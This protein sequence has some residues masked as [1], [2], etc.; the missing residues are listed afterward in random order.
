M[1]RLKSILKYTPS[2]SVQA[3]IFSVSETSG[4]ISQIPPVRKLFL[5]KPA[6]S[7][8]WMRTFF[9][10]RPHH[11]SLLAEWN[12]PKFEQVTQQN[13]EKAVGCAELADTRHYM[14][15]QSW[16]SGKWGI[17]WG[18]LEQ[19]LEW[20]N[21]PKAPASSNEAA[22]CSNQ[23]H[24]AQEGPDVARTLAHSFQHSLH[25]PFCPSA[26]IKHS[27]YLATGK[28]TDTLCTWIIIVPLVNWR[29][30]FFFFF[31]KPKEKVNN[32]FFYSLPTLTSWTWPP[33]VSD[34][35]FQL[36][37]QCFTNEE[38]IYITHLSARSH[39]GTV[40]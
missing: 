3:F 10:Q 22:W 21:A 40:E 4:C 24:W 17:W 32:S 34:T 35:S 16:L 31:S 36:P 33:D 15:L 11:N 12:H 6:V 23:V 29:F 1:G 19:W 38:K 28:R 27:Q 37:Q 8:S 30:F 18:A 13:A 9:G 14:V 25:S 2:L 26:A 5:W 7:W 20:Q 39:P